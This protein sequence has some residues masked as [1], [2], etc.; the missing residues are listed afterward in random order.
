[1]HCFMNHTE[2]AKS[3]STGE[4]ILWNPSWKVIGRNGPINKIFFFF[5]PNAYML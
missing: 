1:M 3:K 2:Q 5:I 4:F